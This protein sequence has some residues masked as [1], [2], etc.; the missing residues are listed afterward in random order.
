LFA[1]ALSTIDSGINSMTAVVVYDWLGGREVRLR[2]SRLLS[3]VFGALVVGAAL[4]TPLLGEFLIEAISKIVGV[5]LGLL[6]GLFL[7]GMLIRRASP[8]GAW[9]GLITGSIALAMTWV[10]TPLPHWWYGGVSIAAAFGGGWLGSIL[11][12]GDTKQPNTV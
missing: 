8:A 3:V 2:T 10:L 12:P 11:M 1:A 9:A 6:L 5:F 7:L 4:L